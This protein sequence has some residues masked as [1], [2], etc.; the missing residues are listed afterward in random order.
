MHSGQKIDGECLDEM[1]QHR[2]ALME[3]HRL[4]PELLNDCTEDIVKFCKN[5]KVNGKTI[6]CLME[7]A[8]IRNE[9]EMISAQCRARVSFLLNNKILLSYFMVILVNL[10]FRSWRT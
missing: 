2:K 5:R 8:L 4:T 7:H 3:D 1:K 9:E 6:H 10:L